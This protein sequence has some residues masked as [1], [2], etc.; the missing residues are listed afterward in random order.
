L[1]N[2]PIYKPYLEDIMGYS[3]FTEEQITDF[4]E[5]AQEMGIGH[6]RKNGGRS[7]GIL[8]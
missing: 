2:L 5:T 7:E 3:T 1:P 6:P 8:F 4:I